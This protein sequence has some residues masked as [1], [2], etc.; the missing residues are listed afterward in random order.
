MKAGLVTSAV[1]R[2]GCGNVVGIAG[3]PHRVAPPRR[4]ETFELSLFKDDG[5]CPASRPRAHPAR[6]WEGKRCEGE[7]GGETPPGPPLCPHLETP[8]SLSLVLHSAL[9]DFLK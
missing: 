8:S 5:T 4:L 9:G 6:H 3:Q 2:N 1:R 7:E